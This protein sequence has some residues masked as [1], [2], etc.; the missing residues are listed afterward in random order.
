MDDST[1]IRKAILALLSR[2]GENPNRDGLAETPARFE[3]QLSECLSGYGQDPLEH[4]KLFDSGDY[5]DLVVVSNIS[6]SSLCEHHLLP[7]YGTVDIAYIPNKKIL[8]LSKFA[9]ITDVFSKRLQVQE[10]LTQELA[11][12]LHEQLQ[13]E[14]LLIKISATHTCMTIRGVERPGSVTD[15]FSS[16]GDIEKH[17]HHVEFFQAM[18]K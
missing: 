4:V 17:R 15:T 9:R 3:K 11:N 8:G 18:R 5:T 2:L 6:F 16:R 14:L 12:F 10:R 7:F 1:D 13:P